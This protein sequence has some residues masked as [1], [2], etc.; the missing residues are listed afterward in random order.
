M[1][2]KGQTEMSECWIFGSAD[3][4]GFDST[5]I[6]RDAFVI[7]ADGGYGHVKRLGINP[8]IILGDF[9]SLDEEIS[10]RCEIITA[11][12]QKDDTDMM[13]AVKK[14]LSIGYKNI[15]LCGALGGRFDHTFANIQTLE[16]IAENG[17]TGRIF[18]SNDI[19]MLQ[20]SLK[21]QYKRA[22]GYYFSLFSLANETIISVTGVKY[23]LFE[24]PLKRS[25]PLGVSN[26]IT[27]DYA[28][29]AI[30][31]GKLLVVYSKKR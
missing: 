28:C 9:D 6:P 5:V 12:A 17:G 8:D 29:V 13:L 7:A 18:S 15:T 14:A 30:K 27:D 10:H 22:D 1:G 20:D 26:E 11:P 23:P 2:D 3:A 21:C 19:I 25:F 31:S 24:Y 16:Y 4:D